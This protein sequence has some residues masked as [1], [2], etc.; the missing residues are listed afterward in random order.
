LCVV[1]DV[2]LTLGESPETHHL[3]NAVLI[4]GLSVQDV[5][6]ASA[7]HCVMAWSA[8]DPIGTAAA[9]K[10]I[11]S[12]PAER[13]ADVRSRSETHFKASGALSTAPLPEYCIRFLRLGR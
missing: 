6:A 11:S 3:D 10:A 13:V 1:Y 2:N 4:S 7:E 9:R 5:V 12:F 8:L